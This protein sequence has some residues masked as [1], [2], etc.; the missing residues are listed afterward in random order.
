M[1]CANPACDG[2]LFKARV[3]PKEDN[4]SMELTCAKCG[5]KVKAW[6]TN[7]Q[8]KALNGQVASL[9]DDLTRLS[10]NIDSFTNLLM[11]KPLTKK[12]WWQR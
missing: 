4:L 3:L 7:D 10:R 6:V 8:L 11:M 12:H 9:H 5:K 2:E 1:K